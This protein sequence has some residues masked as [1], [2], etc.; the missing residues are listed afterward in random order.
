M[1]QRLRN[2]AR[3]L[4]AETVVL[5]FCCKHPGTPLTAKILATAVV[6]YALSPIDL[7]PDFIPVIGHL[8]DL[9]LVPLGIYIALRLIPE[10]VIAQSRQK[11]EV[12]NAEKKRTLR[13]YFAAALILLV[14]IA[15]AYWG[16]SLYAESKKP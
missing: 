14:W 5:W 2:W 6:A 3:L 12:W 4:K 1:W 16:W 15:L 9:I 11:A 13:N 8:D 7:I 10:H